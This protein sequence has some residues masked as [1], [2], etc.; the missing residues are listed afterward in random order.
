LLLVLLL[1]L[2]FPLIVGFLLIRSLAL[3]CLL[4]LQPLAL[5]ILLLAYVLQLLLMLLLELR[6]PIWRRI[7][8]WPS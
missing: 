6:I 1:H 4:L 3:L 5:L 7:R 2:L 8:C